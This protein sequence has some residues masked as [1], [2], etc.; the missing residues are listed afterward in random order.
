MPESYLLMLKQ[1]GIASPSSNNQ[2]LS[3]TVNYP[4]IEK[5]DNNNDNRW[6]LV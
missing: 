3:E 5:N 6:F 1:Q 4:S 2:E